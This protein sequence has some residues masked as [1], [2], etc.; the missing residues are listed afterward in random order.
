MMDGTVLARCATTARLL[1]AAGV[2]ALWGLAMSVLAIFLLVHGHL[3]PNF[4]L[5][6]SVIAA[7]LGL[8]ERY[9]AFRIRFDA[10]LF[11][12]MARGTIFSLT[13]LDQA[14]NEAGLRRSTSRLRSLDERLLGARQLIKRHSAL[15]ACQSLALTAA[16]L[17]QWFL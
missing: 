8:P 5:V 17:N 12:D 6:G 7:L 2:A 9:F 16:L 14:L 11:K 10:G 15:V 4:A 13:A 1:E 3:R